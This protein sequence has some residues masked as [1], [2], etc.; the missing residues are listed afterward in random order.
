[1]RPK[2]AYESRSKS[3]KKKDKFNTQ[4][5]SSSVSRNFDKESHKDW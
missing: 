1:M 4:Q 2:S 3:K 5:V